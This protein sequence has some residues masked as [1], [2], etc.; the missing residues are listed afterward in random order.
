M[1]VLQHYYNMA[2][3]P[4]DIGV[5]MS[6]DLDDDSMTRTLVRDEFDRILG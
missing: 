2:T 5:A 3:N 6:C 1:K 4:G